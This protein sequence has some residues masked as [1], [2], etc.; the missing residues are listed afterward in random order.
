MISVAQV[1]PQLRE[2][3]PEPSYL[4]PRTQGTRTHAPDVQRVIE[5]MGW[6]VQPWLAR[7]LPEAL[8]IDD[9]GSW[10]H[11]D[12]V[13]SV[14]RQAGKTTALGP[15]AVHRA[16][17]IPNAACWVTAQTRQFAADLI[18]QEW[19][20][21]AVPATGG[22]LRRAMGSEALTAGTG[23]VRPFPPTPDGLHGRYAHLVGV[24]EVWALGEGEALEQAIR[25]TLTTTG[26]QI[27]WVST[28]GDATSGLLRRLVA[29]GRR[30]EA[31]LA[32]WAVP[33][34]EAD[35]VGEWL[36]SRGPGDLERAVDAVLA[37]HPG[38]LARRQPILAAAASMSPGE[39]L[40]AYGNVWT[41]AST[42][43]ISALTW[44]ARRR[45]GA[46]P[47]PSRPLHLGVSADPDGVGGYAAIV[48][49]WHH[50]GR[51]LVDV[52]QREQGTEWLAEAVA[53]WQATLSPTRVAVDRND[54]AAAA[55]ETAVLRHGMPRS[56]V[57][58][59]TAA[60]YSLAC[61]RFAELARVDGD[62]EHAGDPALAS[63]VVAADK[64]ALGDR[65]VWDRRRTLVAPLVAATVAVRSLERVRVAG[66]P[67]IQ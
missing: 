14:P 67:K 57:Y 19:A 28:A 41:E 61:A 36:H 46:W 43:V 30:G 22:H 63:A 10:V 21:R 29:A 35:R 31:F 23:K 39:F 62:L 59:L 53:H 56:R 47:R 54:P 20:P 58:D 6:R 40:R 64:R 7:L 60:D 18:V 27:W 1:G 48:A 4:T 42:G 15:V 34:D 26:G 65:W 17:A 5:A 9:D 38:Q 2:A 25:P 16:L 32:E 12:V 50:E 44:A 13:I 3:D 52:V 11:S 49:A 45:Q 66:K 24:D 8:A 51:T 37:H 33:Q 55:V